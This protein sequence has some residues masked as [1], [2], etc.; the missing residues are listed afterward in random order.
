MNRGER[1]VGP[2]M[3]RGV[4]LIEVMISIVISMLLVLVIYQIYEVSEGQKRTITAGSDAQQNASYGLYALGRDLSIAGNGVAPSAQALAGCAAD[5]LSPIPVVIAT[6][7]TGNAPDTVTVFYGGSSSLSTPVPLQASHAIG[8]STYVVR[9]PVGFSPKDV[10]AAV[11]GNNCTLSTINDAGVAVDANGMATITHTVVPDEVDHNYG[12]VNAS[13]V[14]LGKKEA[15]GRITYSVDTTAHT[16]RTQAQLP[17][18]GPVAPLVS[19]VVNLKAQYGLDT[20]EPPDGIIDA[21]EDSNGAWYQS[22]A[23]L[24]PDTTAWL[25]AV[26]RLLAV[27]VAIVTR[28]AQYEKDAVTAGPLRMLDD[29]VSMTLNADDQHYR[30]KV[31]ETIVPLRNAF[32]N[33]Q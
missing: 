20:T 28:S 10:I 31:L 15:L 30:Y 14:N 26:R 8:D 23:G 2:G 18:Q 24:K 17:T 21:W 22:L 5:A 12:A 32:W 19:D 13:L 27:R 6:G 25:K 3:E 33:P 16:L 7:A 4:G 1:N 9:A 29:T 11:Q